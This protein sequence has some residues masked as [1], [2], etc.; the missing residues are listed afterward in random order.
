MILKNIVKLTMSVALFTT[1]SCV[2]E[3]VDGDGRGIDDKNIDPSF[4]VTKTAENKYSLKR[5]LNNYIASKW[6]ID[7]DGYYV[8]KAEENLFLPDAGTFVVEHQAIGMGGESKIATQTLVV[9]TSDPNAGNMVKGGR[10]D[11]PEEVAKWTIHKISPSGAQWVF[12]NKKATLVAQDG[13]QQGFYQAIDV[14][15]GQKYSIDLVASSETP[16]VN[17]WFEVYVLDHAP[18]DGQDVNGQ[19]YRNIN[20]WAGCGLAKFSGKVS[21]I[22]CDDAKNSGK[23]TATKTGTVYLEV[24]CGGSK[25]NALSVDKIEFRKTT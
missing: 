25:I 1:A 13:N 4:T 3:T 9:P 6:N 12:A 11:T 2:P 7:E 17:T 16:L 15:A 14:V 23:Y 19:V 18:V 5:N 20:T 10:L 22:G 8:G 21:T 24:K